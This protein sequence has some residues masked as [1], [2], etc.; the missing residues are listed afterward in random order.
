MNTKLAATYV[1]A[2]ALLLPIAAFSADSIVQTPKAFVK[3]SVITTKIKAELA[4]QKLSS[5]VKI[6][7]DTDDNGV[8]NLGG[9][10]A[11]QAAADKAVSIARSVEGVR[12]VE[13]HIK[14]VGDK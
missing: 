6:S 9:T 12:S 14:V 13:S 7:V 11:T 2:G 8:V 4:E 10:A 5:L 3:D 1:V